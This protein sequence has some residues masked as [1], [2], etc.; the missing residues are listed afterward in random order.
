MTSTAESNEFALAI[1]K[2]ER[3]K[4]EGHTYILENQDQLGREFFDLTASDLESPYNR[5]ASQLRSSGIYQSLKR[6]G[7]A[8]ENVGYFVRPC[9]SK[10]PLIWPICDAEC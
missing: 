10:R 5:R 2:V 6:I 7:V 8:S 4:P 1:K 9:C 3:Y